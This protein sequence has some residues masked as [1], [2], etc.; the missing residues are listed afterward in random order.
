M[1]SRAEHQSSVGKA[2]GTLR[3]T[4]GVESKSGLSGSAARFIARSSRAHRSRGQLGFEWADGAV[5]LVAS[6]PD[7][8]IGRD[9]NGVI[10]SWNPAAQSLYGYSSLEA[11]GTPYDLVV[12]SVWRD[13]EAE[14]AADVVRARVT[15]RYQAERVGKDGAIADVSVQISPVHDASGAVIAIST[16]EQ[17]IGGLTP[18]GDW[19]SEVGSHLRV[20]FEE[21]PVGIG[22]VS[23]HH[24]SAGRLLRVNRSLCEL[25][26]HS[27]DQLESTTVQALLHPDDV[28]ADLAAV[29]QLLEGEVSEFQLEQ[30]LLHVQRHFTWVLTSVSLARDSTGK[31]LYCIRQSQDIEERKRYERELGYLVEHDS[32]TG[33]LNRGGFVRELT[34]HMAEAR[35]YGD[36]GCILFFDLDDFKGVNDTLGHHMGDEVISAV[37]R[38]VLERLRETDVFARLGGDEFAV[39]LPHA[40]TNEAQTVAAK[41]LGAI[42]DECATVVGGVR[43]ITVSIGITAFDLCGSQTAEDILGDADVAMYAAKESGKNRAIFSN[44]ATCGRSIS[45][46]PWAERVRNALEEGRFELH[47]QPIVDLALDRV[48]QWELLLRLPDE[49]GELILPAQFLY[50][51]ERS[52]LIVEIDRWVLAEAM[53]LLASHRDMGRELCLEVNISGR[54]VGDVALLELI[55]WGIESLEIDPSKLILEVTETAA[56]A[57]MDRARGFATRLR[58]LGCRFALDDFGAGFGSF[59]YLKHIPFDFVKIDGEFVHNL[60]SSATDRLILDSIVQMSK[61][62]GKRTIAECVGDSETVTVLREHGVDYAQGFHLGAPMSV[63]AMLEGLGPG[64]AAAGESA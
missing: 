6:L 60:P 9:L 61:G 19:S 58:S 54:S 56:I 48:S 26:G 8:V 31:P 16:V 34:Q 7:A 50:T 35:R 21:A 2:S 52:G 42:E 22:L 47:C 15:D 29:T 64:E 24:H 44:A 27:V 59:Y 23:V 37:A 17:A 18:A 5:T 3:Q 51:A 32:L 13:R 39:L 33:L 28:S 36:G 25:T 12:P 62:L 46:V 14:I 11:V 57:N 40:G 1:A 41:L 38:I 49:H 55:E 63:S 4:Q 45:R 43:R 30:R 20:A 10:A 53:R